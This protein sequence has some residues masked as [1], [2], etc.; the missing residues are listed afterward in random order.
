MK[1]MKNF[2][3]M[4][5]LVCGFSFVVTSCHDDNNDNGGNNGG[6]NSDDP[7]VVVPASETEEAKAA[8]NWLANMTDIGEFTDDWAS[9][10]YEPTIGVESQN[11]SNT[12]VVVV[13]DIDYAK[14]NFASISGFSL[15]E[16]STTQTQTID[17]VGSVTWTPSPAG[18]SN[19]ATVDVNTQLIP[20]LSKIVYCT[21]EQAGDNGGAFD[22][23]AFYRFGD[24]LEDNQGYLWVCVK[25]AFGTGTAPQ[26]QGYWINILNRDPDTGKSTDGR[27]PPI[28]KA[29]ICEDYDNKYSGNTIKLPTK[30][31]STKEMT[32]NLANLIWALL[33]PDAY[34]KTVGDNGI[35][36]GGYDY[37][38]NGALFCKR[39]AQRWSVTQD[40][41]KTIWEKLFNRTYDQMKQIKKLN[42]YYKGYNFTPKNIFSS[43]NLG[44]AIVMG[45][46][47]YEKSYAT[48]ASEDEE[49]NIEMK[50]TGAGFD[51]LRYCS[52]PDQN[53]ECA[54]SGKAGYAPAQQF[55][56]TEGYWIVRQKTSKE[57]VGGWTT[58]SVYINLTNMKEIYRYN[59]VFKKAAGSNTTVDTDDDIIVPVEPKNLAVGNVLGSDARFYVTAQE[60]R[61]Q[62]GKDP[63]A[64]VA[65]IS[66][67]GWDM[68]D[69]EGRYNCVLM[70]IKHRKNMYKWGEEA[71]KDGCTVTQLKDSVSEPSYVVDGL[72]EAS[73]L[74][75]SCLKNHNHPAAE[76]AY[77]TPN[78]DAN[79]VRVGLFSK[80]FLPGLGHFERAV[81]GL[82]G[83]T[84][85]PSNGFG[86][87]INK[88]K[89]MGQLLETFEKAG[90]EYEYHQ[91]I[92][93]EPRYWTS[94]LSDMKTGGGE[95]NK[96]YTFLF[97]CFFD[98]GQTLK[99]LTD[100]VTKEHYVVPFLL[101]TIVDD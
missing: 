75:S 89:L 41:G 70:S 9:K 1:K 63:F 52:D 2:L 97:Q 60:A 77:G 47:K 76:A 35:G 28:P 8:L 96:A 38:Y 80:W 20:H 95:Y 49:K 72:N 23:T 68:V 88:N 4:A 85:N 43:T 31:M 12:R 44:C 59:A 15:A 6:N 50:E 3:L 11:Q 53:P 66:Q 94:T 58:P 27:V 67:G 22:G 78:W 34:H 24:V 51:M 56:D 30:L 39:V 13:A 82:G 81:K 100:D 54:S 98:K 7:E 17:G 37:K 19:L 79:A 99:S 40:D 69:L 42:F 86:A 87:P 101:Y 14:M 92:D 71:Y 21:T 61:R 10:T 48:Q 84:W 64:I 36:L 93:G 5:A 46:K 55:S 45:T 90:L 83:F 32:H 25:P 16:L 62:T 73:R 65:Y 26:Q 33:D 29:N 91:L 57:L 74:V 18:A